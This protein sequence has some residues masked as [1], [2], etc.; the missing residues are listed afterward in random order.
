M[1]ACA[2][3]SVDG[4]NLS[5]AD[6]A[7]D[8]TS[9]APTS[10]AKKKTRPAATTN[11]N[12]ETEGSTSSADTKPTATATSTSTAPTA[13]ATTT[14][15]APVNQLPDCTAGGDPDACRQCCLQANPGAV[16]FENDYDDCLN[17]G[18]T[19]ADFDNCR[20]QHLNL[21]ASSSSCRANH[22]CMENSNCLASNACSPL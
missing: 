5:G 7:A 14:A 12:G 1:V 13:S 9:S 20:Q 21:C 15:S 3:P 17:A 18:A 4:T 10:T 22:A 19:Q 6:T 8:D 11:A 16:T 2:T